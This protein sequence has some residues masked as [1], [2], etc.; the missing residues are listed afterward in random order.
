MLDLCG[1][2]ASCKDIIKWKDTGTLYTV[3]LTPSKDSL[4]PIGIF[5]YRVKKEITKSELKNDTT[6]TLLLSTVQ[7]SPVYTLTDSIIISFEDCT[8]F[9][10]SSKRET[11]VVGDWKQSYTAA[12][13][14]NEEDLELLSTKTIKNIKLFGFEEKSDEV[15]HWRFR[16]YVKCILKV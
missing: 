15:F 16:E 3:F 6:Y 4:A 13:S 7:S 8:K 2:T 11:M 10:K 14:L 9:S 1:Q 12:I 5:E